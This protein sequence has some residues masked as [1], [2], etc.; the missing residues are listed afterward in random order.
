M[1]RQLEVHSME[2]SSKGL[3]A[4]LLQ[5][6]AKR[7]GDLILLHEAPDGRAILG[8]N[9]LITISAWR[10]GSRCRIELRESAD[11]PGSGRSELPVDAVDPS[12]ALRL[13]ENILSAVEFSGSKA[14]SE[15]F[16]WLGFI[17]YELGVMLEL[18][19]LYTD[20]A[21]SMPLLHWQLFSH[22]FIFDPQRGLW[23]L[24]YLDQPNTPD[25]VPA[26]WAE[27]CGL[28][29][30][31]EN[32]DG[33]KN[34]ITADSEL[35]QAPNPI[36]FEKAVRRCL[37]YIGAGDIYQAN[38]AASWL[39]RTPINPVEIYQRMIALSPAPFSAFLRFGEYSICSISP[40]LFISRRGD[41]LYTQPIKGTR[42]RDLKDLTAD[43]LSR[44]DLLQSDKDRAEL[45][46]IVDLLRNDLG[47]VCVPGSVCVTVER[48]IDAHPTVWHTSARIE[49]L[50]T[51]GAGTRW[52]ALAADVCPGGSITGVP[53]IRAMQIIAELE[54][55]P[56]GVYCGNIGWIHP[57]GDAALNI[58]IRTLW[59]ANGLVQINA[60]SGIVAQ[61]DPAEEFTEIQAKAYAL[62]RSLHVSL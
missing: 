1:N 46:M 26:I 39:V 56:R 60:G 15:L 31:A 11:F 5:V 35:I 44:L 6:L 21:V 49:G 25:A 30:D 37:D 9:P 4:Q 19:Q 42:R 12:E 23:R 59:T 32:F 3:P 13:W 29:H 48:Q 55:A 2:V 36:R 54:P 38:L 61:S 14:P 28:L 18:P 52:A 51:P 16:G 7:P 62:L 33:D 50:M 10:D 53:K 58:A 47:R 20:Q 24:I 27:M 8:V 57:S 17:G 22:Y 40:E 34:T 41:R 45:A 43:N